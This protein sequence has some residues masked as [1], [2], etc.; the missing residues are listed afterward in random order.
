VPVAQ[1]T[2][3]PAF[4]YFGA[5]TRNF[6]NQNLQM[7]TPSEKLLK[8]AL[9]KRG[10][11]FTNDQIVSDEVSCAFALS[12]V[13]HE[14]DSS[15]PI[16]KGTRELEDEV[17]RCGKFKKIDTP[18]AGAIVI[19]ATGTNSRPD[20]MPHGHC[21]IYVDEVNIMS[22]DSMS[23]LWIKN[24]TRETWRQRYYYK[25]GFNVHLYEKVA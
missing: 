15:F 24:Y 13:I 20:I 16:I 25:G 3:A 21:G 19:C 12:T 14:V 10:T 1:I 23:G 18:K 5:I 7:E 6:I 9:A 11:D 8:E 17:I 2:I 4:G 22:N